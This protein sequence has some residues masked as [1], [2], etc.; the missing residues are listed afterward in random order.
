MTHL[1]IWSSVTSFSTTG[2]T[3]FG[4]GFLSASRTDMIEAGMWACCYTEKQRQSVN[5]EIWREDSKCESNPESSSYLMRCEGVDVLQERL[6]HLWAAFKHAGQLCRRQLQENAVRLR[7]RP[8]AAFHKA[9]P[10]LG[11]LP[12]LQGKTKNK[13]KN[14]AIDIY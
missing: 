10:H 1:Y 9:L 8:L 2:S 4:S 5:K 3:G 14:T 7:L 12:H 11:I 13:K 6:S